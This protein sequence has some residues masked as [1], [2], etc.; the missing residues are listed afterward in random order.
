MCSEIFAAAIADRLQC[1]WT[2]QAYLD[3]MGMLS[4]NVYL[5]RVGASGRQILVEKVIDHPTAVGVVMYREIRDAP[6]PPEPDDARG[7]G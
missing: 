1:G 7:G 4:P 6:R 3:E 5:W 2:T